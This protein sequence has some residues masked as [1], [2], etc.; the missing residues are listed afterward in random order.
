MSLTTE[1]ITAKLLE[2]EIKPSFQRIKIFEFLVNHHIHPTVEEIFNGVHKEIPTLSKATVYNTLNTFIEAKL[3]RVIIIEGHETRYEFGLHDHGHFKCESC[4]KIYD[5]SI[6]FDSLNAG[7]DLSGFEI[8]DKD[9]YFSGICPGCL[10][11]EI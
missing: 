5:F 8:N 3:L 9:V 4:G 10:Q 6:D 1:E 11:N 2:R 7:N